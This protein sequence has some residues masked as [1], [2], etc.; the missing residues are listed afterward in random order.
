MIPTMIGSTA[1]PP[2]CERKLPLKK[3]ILLIE[4][5]G[6]RRDLRAEVLRKLGAQVDFAGDIAAAR[7]LWRPDAYRLVLL[8]LRPDHKSACAFGSEMEARAPRQRVAFLTGKPE[9]LSDRLPALGAD[10][11][12]PEPAE[13]ASQPGKAN[14]GPRGPLFTAA[15]RISA[16]RSMQNGRSK[17]EGTPQQSFGELV[18]KITEE[19]G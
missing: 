7:D 1:I 9:Y 12:A 19:G 17:P 16:A 4:A 5:S 18:R 10:I 15:A 13:I 3:D 6:P 2:L 11:P 14:H 8:D